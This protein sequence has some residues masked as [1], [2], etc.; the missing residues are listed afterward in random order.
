MV[1]VNNP[2]FVCGL[3]GSLWTGNGVY[4]VLHGFALRPTDSSDT[5][6]RSLLFLSLIYE[7]TI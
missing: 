6:S 7:A 2:E 3:E 5:Q 1:Y 4:D